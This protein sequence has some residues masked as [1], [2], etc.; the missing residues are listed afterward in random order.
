MA[1]VLKVSF[2]YVFNGNPEILSGYGFPLSRER[3]HNLLALYQIR[4]LNTIG[5]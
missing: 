3:Q 4:L 2:P 5:I 1:K